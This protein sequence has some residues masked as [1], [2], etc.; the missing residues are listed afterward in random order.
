MIARGEQGAQG[1]DEESW[2]R[3]RRVDFELGDKYAQGN[4]AAGNLNASPD[5]ILEGTRMQ[6]LLLRIANVSKANGSSYSDSAECGHEAGSGKGSGSASGSASASGSVN[7]GT[8][9]K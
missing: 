5:P 8:G 3:D 6:A 2:A 1:T 7:V 9:S 4:A